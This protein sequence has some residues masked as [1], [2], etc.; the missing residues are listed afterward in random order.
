MIIST[1]FLL[2]F[3]QC[4]YLMLDFPDYSAEQLLRSSMQVMRGHKGRL[5]YLHVSFLPLLL[6]A[7]LSCGVGMLWIRPYMQMTYTC[8]FLDL[9]N[10]GKTSGEAA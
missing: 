6:L 3:S 2:V 1:L 9:M 4:F 7:L 8:F 10:P 5:F